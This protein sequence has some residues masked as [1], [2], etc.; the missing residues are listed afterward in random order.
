MEN[1]GVHGVVITEHNVMW[2]K[3][4]I[5]KLNALLKGR[6]VYRGVELSCLEGHFIVIGLDDLR[7]IELNCPVAQV[8]V[9]ARKCGAAVIFAHPHLKCSENHEPVDPFRLP[10]GIDAIEVSSTATR[11]VHS[12][13]AL[14]YAQKIGWHPVSGSDAHCCEHVGAVA[15]VFATLPV[16]EKELAEEIRKGRG[17][18]T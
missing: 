14:Y 12:Q 13:N 11:G 4:E 10:Y 18:Y 9:E 15:T 2:E 7:N 8:I 1:S 17:R 5:N 6:Q 3:E 16:D